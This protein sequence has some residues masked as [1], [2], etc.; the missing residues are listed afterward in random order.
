MNIGKLH[1]GMLAIMT[2]FAV[3][4][5]SACAAAGGQPPLV[6]DPFEPAEAD[7][8]QDARSPVTQKLFGTLQAAQN[9]LQTVFWDPF[10]RPYS[11]A[12][13]AGS[14]TLKTG[15]AMVRR[16]S[17]ALAMPDP[18]G[19]HKPLYRSEPMDLVAWERALNR[20][21]GKR[22]AS[23]GRM[24][25]LIDGD[26]FFPRLRQSI[27]EAE[28][29]VHVRTYIFDN[30][31][32]SVD[33]ADLLRARSQEIDVRVLLDGVG[34]LL[35]TQVHPAS[36]PADFQ[37]PL[38]MTRYLEDGSEV[39]VRTHSNPF[40]TGDHVKST[41]VDG[42]LAFVGGMNIGREYRYEWHDMMM[43]VTGAV[44][45]KIERDADM[46]WAKAGLFGDLGQFVQAMRPHRKAPTGDGY[47]I[48]V[49]RTLPKDS[50]I[51]RTQLA[52]IRRAQSYI[53]IQNAYFS[54][55]VILYELIRARQRGVDVRVII[56]REGNHPMMNLSNGV[57]INTMLEH[58]IRVYLYP[59]M[60][61]IKAAVFDGW[62]C[63]GSANFDA[64]SLRINREMN[65]ATSDPDTVDDLLERLFYRDFRVSKEISEPTPVDWRHSLAEIIADA[66][67]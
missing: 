16:T 38:S 4:V 21:V 10:T 2:L 52:A 37:P 64:M 22:T 51:Y 3:T 28:R 20:I 34:T 67:L 19:R 12:T 66:A 65:L 33:I 44:V 26:E 35:G 46:A 62:A 54:D 47:P 13:A 58:G 23:T 36:L 50:Q 55:D 6:A 31:D 8:R 56:P 25:F 14:L 61:H 39:K 24:E 40:M 27:G 43:E 11:T 30:D 53:F 60:S 9:L 57:A 41:I 42:K 59:G 48:R 5:Q 49:L 29:T 32:V 7:D 63:V 15:G 45:G 18:A 17:V 1:K